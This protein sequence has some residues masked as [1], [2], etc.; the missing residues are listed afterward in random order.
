L[1]HALPC[2]RLRLPSPPFAVTSWTRINA[3][4]LNRIILGADSPVCRYG[5]ST[6]IF[7]EPSEALQTQ[8]DD[9][10]ARVQ[11][12]QH[13]DTNSTPRHITARPDQRS[14]LVFLLEDYPGEEGDQNIG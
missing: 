11:I 3:R 12:V 9:L 4:R 7:R 5:L 1:V 2:R 6:A 10:C 8:T 14:K 13:L